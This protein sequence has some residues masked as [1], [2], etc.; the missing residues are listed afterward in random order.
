[1]LSFLCILGTIGLSFLTLGF[2]LWAWG[3]FLDVQDHNPAKIRSTMLLIL[4][5]VSLC[6]ISF[7]FFELTYNWVAVV[8]L[9][10]NLWGSFDALLRFPAAHDL[11]SFFAV[12][13]I[14]LHLMKGFAY[15]FGIIGLGTHIS[16]FVLILV[17]NIW[18]L[19]VL[20]LMALPLNPAE[21]VA[22]KESDDVDLVVRVWE[23]S[24]C[25]TER[26]RCLK[27]CRT[28][29]HKRLFDVSERSRMA[30]MAICA[31]SPSYRRVFSKGRWKV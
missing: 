24:T 31:A 23:L 18:A 6:D 13:Q 3:C 22:D 14:V 19:P 10:I 2:A 4:S 16:E 11:E 26:Q 21:Q 25:H 30:K 29:F 27:T 12:K 17:L 8:A 28:W 7:S 1:M 9:S 5:V 20:Y 15:A